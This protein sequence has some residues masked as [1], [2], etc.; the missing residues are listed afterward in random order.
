MGA[1]AQGIRAGR[2][3]VELF[4]DD[5]KMQ[6]VLKRSQVRLLSFS[7][8]VHKVGLRMSGLGVALSLPFVKA[9]S[10]FVKF[11][12]QMRIV[13]GV[14]SASEKE[15][16]TLEKTARRLAQQKGTAFLATD[17]ASLMAELGRAGFASEEINKMTKSVLLLARASQTELPV[18]AEITGSTM[19][20][21]A[22]DASQASLVTDMLSK[23]ANAS[24][25]S[26]ISL[27]AS[28]QYAGKP[29]ADLGYSLQESLSIIGVLGNL[30]IV[31]TEAGTVTRRLGTEMA[32]LAPEMEKIFGVAF[33]DG[34]G[35]ALKM[36]D[37][38]EKVAQSTAKLSSSERFARLHKAFGLL[39]ITGA[40]ALGQSAQSAKAL[41][42]EL[43]NVAG[44][45]EEAAA[46]MDRGLG[47]SM[48]R[49]WASLFEDELSV[50]YALEKHLIPIIDQ[51]TLSFRQLAHW[52]HENPLTVKEIAKGAVAIAAVGTSLVGLGAAGGLAA[53]NLRGIGYALHTALTP[54]RLLSNA[55]G[56]VLSFAYRAEKLG[57]SW[58]G[59]L[60]SNVIGGGR[61][62]GK[63]TAKK[64]AESSWVDARGAV[65]SVFAT[66][67]D[68]LNRR[69]FP[70]RKS[71]P[72]ARAVD[73]M[74]AMMGLS[75][76]AMPWPAPLG[77]AKP[78]PGLWDR[79]S[80][81]IRRGTP[82]VPRQRG[83][84]KDAGMIG[85]V[86]SSLLG[87]RGQSLLGKVRRMT[88]GEIYEHTKTADPLS[89]VKKTIFGLFN[90]KSRDI[91]INPNAF[92]GK[93]RSRL[94]EVV[95][96]EIGHAVDRL[97]GSR[98]AYFGMD[99]LATEDGTRKRSGT[100]GRGFIDRL[101][102][103]LMRRRSAKE[104]SD[105]KYL[106][107]GKE[108]FARFF[109]SQQL[110]VQVA[111]AQQATTE[112]SAR[113][114]VK[115]GTS[116]IAAAA[117]IFRMKTSSLAVRAEMTL[118]RG[119]LAAGRAVMAGWNATL[120]AGRGLNQIWQASYQASILSLAASR[121]VILS[122]RG[123]MLGL[124]ATPR[125]MGAGISAM[126]TGIR[127]A[128]IGMATLRTG[129]VV[130][131]AAGKTTWP[132]LISGV[133]QFWAWSV[134][135]AKALPGLA[136]GMYDVSA[137]AVK[138][139]LAIGKMLVVKGFAGLVSGASLLLNPMTLLVG[140]GI[141]VVANWDRIKSA[142]TGVVSTA[143]GAL[144]S[145]WGRIKSDAMPTL[146]GI[147][148]T[149]LTSFGAISEAVQA[150]DIPAAMQILWGGIRAIWQEGFGYLR[151]KWFDLTTW[152][153]DA[154]NGVLQVTAGY[155]ASIAN[156][157]DV[158]LFDWFGI[159]LNDVTSAFSTAWGWIAEKGGAVADWIAETWKGV[160]G[161]I[162][163]SGEGFTDIIWHGME[164]IRKTIAA[165]MLKMM[166]FAKLVAAFDPTGA[167]G[168]LLD[169]LG[170]GFDFNADD[171]VKELDDL[172]EK[173]DAARR[174]IAQG[175]DPEQQKRLAEAKKKVEDLEKQREANALAARA[176][177]A[178]IE[179]DLRQKLELEKANLDAV[180]EETKKKRELRE[181]T[182]SAA[183]A[184]R[185]AA[186]AGTAGGGQ[187]T[188]P[189]MPSGLTTQ[190]QRSWMIKERLRQRNEFFAAKKAAAEQ[191]KADELAA[192]KEKQKRL[193]DEQQRRQAGG[194]IPDR[195]LF[196]QQGPSF[197]DEA[198]D[199]EHQAA[200]AKAW[201]MKQALKNR[202]P[203]FAA[204][205][206]PGVRPE[207]KGI[208]AAQ[209]VKVDQTEVV[210]AVGLTNGYMV[211]LIDA[212]RELK[213]N[214]VA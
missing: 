203:D 5:S 102:P 88:T 154:F 38:L 193:A 98:G 27:G 48:R 156:M 20:Q 89:K 178:Q 54:A 118:L 134:R 90:R 201:E 82:K 174:K 144:S 139:A 3:F 17:I 18:A 67:K 214:F 163:K 14:V 211:S 81:L 179:E 30:G 147:R 164:R 108:V 1:T 146:L 99:R 61:K 80:R 56:G 149:A 206:F 64:G 120:A 86:F 209:P 128:A 150:G 130:M 159:R 171:A 28:L 104:Q 95:M 135:G 40:I 170:F 205:Q 114:I 133:K 175:D 182:E 76:M 189:T 109:A 153:G 105:P 115:M 49:M 143:P 94:S 125:L 44:Y 113:S 184:Q 198:A 32:A 73:P 4:A 181:A 23:T 37:V 157:L 119:Q 6:A 70:V 84:L 168:I 55:L 93:N 11:D 186:N 22:M 59:M 106:G 35:N 33:R 50:G 65:S 107:A 85:S 87:D 140:A 78:A 131:S 117:G 96:H 197:F 77:P 2:A 71:P 66:G 29:L 69:Y 57:T 63:R 155:G 138:A 60:M 101:M 47:G 196:L 26:V 185:D 72:A 46:R 10:D 167:A 34:R 112:K 200:V 110:P 187:P 24:A 132:V 21:F 210:D 111:M 152:A 195:D 145:M 137:G 173:R 8:F 199:E 191:K 194:L 62:R 25:T 39:G 161:S 53:L 19:R 136:K 51:V 42:K 160:F 9:T 192:R 31:G 202:I 43:D 142:I 116:A 100:I 68:V 75:S 15:L 148:D 97:A 103:S 36:V 41:Q 58:A 176:D 207:A 165:T 127:G 92:K 52:V 172:F 190:Q 151:L 129:W 204:L 12:D 124:S 212:V 91:A 162:G 7:D 177:R 208:G 79:M 169:Q 13:A 121:P 45:A 213:G 188:G 180:I 74:A 183:N 141:A 158:A 123:A 16:K 166:D 122:L 126:S 83:I